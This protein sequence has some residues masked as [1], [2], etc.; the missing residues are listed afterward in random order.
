MESNII[1]QYIPKRVLDKIDKALL[2]VLDYQEG[3]SRFQ[4]AYDY[5]RNIT[6]N[7]KLVNTII[8]IVK[9]FLNI[10]NITK[11]LLSAYK[12]AS[13]FEFM[14]HAD[15]MKPEEAGAQLREHISG[16]GVSSKII[17]FIF[18]AVMLALKILQARK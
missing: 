4:R 10:P 17:D 6:P 3:A 5:F 13:G 8:L 16:F 18:G 11:V 15:K 9:K 7:V 2:G 1:T 12:M 14:I